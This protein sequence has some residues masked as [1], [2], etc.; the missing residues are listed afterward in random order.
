MIAKKRKRKGLVIVGFRES[1]DR[2]KLRRCVLNQVLGN[3]RLVRRAGRSRCTL[4]SIAKHEQG[5]LVEAPLGL[6]EEIGLQCCNLR[7]CLLLRL[8]RKGTDD[9]KHSN[10]TRLQSLSA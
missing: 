6:H 1:G 8:I 9:H 5:I 3:Q 4:R 10:G 2:L 7:R